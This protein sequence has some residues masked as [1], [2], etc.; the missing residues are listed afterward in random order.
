MKGW[1][2]QFPEEALRHEEAAAG[3]AAERV[4][5]ER[6]FMAVIAN[7]WATLWRSLKFDGYNL[8]IS[9]VAVV[10]PF[11]IQAPRLFAGSI[12]LGDVIQ[13]SQSFGEVQEEYDH[14]DGYALEGKAR[15]VKARAAVREDDGR[16]RGEEPAQ[17]QEGSHRV[18]WVRDAS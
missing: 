5:L 11:L 13:T 10:F 4:T 12:K 15:D 6:G 14:L 2:D 8:S 9:Q 16:D 7:A 3:E 17:C 1:L 18:P